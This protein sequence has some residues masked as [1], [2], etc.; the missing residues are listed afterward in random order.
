MYNNKNTIFFKL[1]SKSI[2]EWN[3]YIN[4]NFVKKL[5]DGSLSDKSFKDYLLQDYI[6]LQRFMKILSIAAFRSKTIDDMHRAIDF[7]IG[8][9]HEIK[10]H[11]NY[12]KRFNL[13]K[14]KVLRTKE[15]KANQNYTSYVMNI[16]LNKSLLELF[17]ALSP[18]IIGYGEI[19]YNLSRKKNWKKSKYSSW[20]KM[21]ASKEYQSLAKSNIRYLDQLN[22]RE[23]IGFNTMLKVFK[24]A[25]V[26]ESEFWQMSL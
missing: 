19:G 11:I 6:F 24:K 9:K 20:I 1:K 10:L 5:S 22:E 23:K 26:L 3:S 21:Y 15:K 13:S 8:I 2:K 16:G 14:N 4:H 25:S 7:I 17:I 18:C 12:C